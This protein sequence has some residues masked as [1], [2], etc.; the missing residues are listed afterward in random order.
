MLL[1]EGVVETPSLSIGMFQLLQRGVK[2]D[3]TALG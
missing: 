2:R 3:E 1:S